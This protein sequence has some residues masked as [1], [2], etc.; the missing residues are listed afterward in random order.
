MQNNYIYH[1]LKQWKQIIP[2]KII[3]HLTLYLN[4]YFNNIFN[5]ENYDFELLKWKINYACHQ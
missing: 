3:M 1:Q 4:W 2:S 5:N